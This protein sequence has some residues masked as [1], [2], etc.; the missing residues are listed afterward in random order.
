M[1]NILLGRGMEKHLTAPWKTQKKP[2]KS[3]RP[4]EPVD[5]KRNTMLEQ[6]EQP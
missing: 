6:P 1:M 5:L 4:L 3:L 2:E